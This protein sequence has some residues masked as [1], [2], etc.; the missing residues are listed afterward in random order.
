VLLDRDGVRAVRQRRAGRDARALA[1]PQRHRRARP[2]SI[3]PTSRSRAGPGAPRSAPDQ[4]VTVHRRVPESGTSAGARD[5]EP[6]RAQRGVQ[7]HAFARKAA[8]GERLAHQR[9][10]LVQR[11]HFE[12]ARACRF[13]ARRRATAGTR[14]LAQRPCRSS[15]PRPGR[16]REPR[17]SATESAFSAALAGRRRARPSSRL[18]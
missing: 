3:A 16:R 10:R 13:A 5:P 15:A 8:R 2:A 6:A 4:R 9:A 12:A 1:A 7:R 11:D 17:A 14:E 18:S